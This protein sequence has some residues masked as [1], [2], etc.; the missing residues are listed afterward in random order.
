MPLRFVTLNR[1]L[2]LDEALLRAGI[3]HTAGDKE[4]RE[5]IYLNFPEIIEN[6]TS[7]T[8]FPV[9]E[10]S[11]NNLLSCLSHFCYR[12]STFDPGFKYLRLIA[13]EEW[14]KTMLR[15]E[16]DKSSRTVH[17]GTPLHQLGLFYLESGDNVLA[18]KYFQLAHIE[19][20]QEFIEG[21]RN[22]HKSQAYRILKAGLLVPE[23]ELEKLRKKAST[24]KGEKYPERVLLDYL[25]D[26]TIN[27]SRA[28]EDSTL[29]LNTN[30]MKS[31]LDE[32]IKADD[33]NIKGKKFT[34]LVSYLF[35]TVGGFEIVGENIL[36]KPIEHDYD[37]LIRNLI[38]K[39]PIFAEFGRYIVAECKFITKKAG[40]DELSKLLY[41]VRYHDCKC[42][43]LFSKKGV[44]FGTNFNL[45]IK[46]AFNRDSTIIL[47]IKQLDVENI[48][49]E[50]TTFLGVLL[51]AYERVKF[52]V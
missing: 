34:R 30:H 47:V 10:G 45:T 42:G 36:T 20:V 51:S 33:S 26:R 6:L 46:K 15:H 39:D 48:I 9:D 21:K 24:H 32:A 7:R 35:S 19:D 5:F 17:K 37:V 3:E 49:K 4:L 18:K 28:V 41:K 40:I 44:S 13:Y 43:V 1:N 22:S 29:V 2:S 52:Q 38:T 8:D 11:D 23:Q 16:K 12:V 27:K 25:L 31:L 50:R 14:Y